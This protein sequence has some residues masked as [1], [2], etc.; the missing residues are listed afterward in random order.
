MSLEDARRRRGVKPPAGTPKTGATFAVGDRVSPADRENVGTVIEVE[1]GGTYV[2]RFVGKEGTA[3]KSFPASSLRPLATPAAEPP[4][5]RR[6]TTAPT[7]S[8]VPFPIEA[9]PAPLRPFVREVAAALPCDPAAVAVPVL[10]ACGAAIG[11]ARVLA[12]KRAWTEPPIVWAGI[13]APSG[14][15]KSPPVEH[16]IAP[17]SKIDLELR[18]GSNRAF[19]E[20]RAAQDARAAAERDRKAEAR[21]HGQSGSGTGLNASNSLVDLDGALE[22]ADGAGP[23]RPPPKRR[24]VVQDITIESLGIILEDNPKGVLIYRDEL[25]SWFGSLTRYSKND[26][27]S[28]WLTLFHARPLTVDRKTGDKIAVAVPNA[29]ASLVGTIQPKVLAAA[30]TPQFRASGGAARL[31]LV[32]PPPQQKVWTEDDL[33]A[34]VEDAYEQIIRR[35]R[36]LE[37]GSDGARTAPV[38]V[39]LTAE[40]RCRWGEFVNE[41]GGKTFAIGGENDDLAAAFSKLEGYAARFA[42]IHH[43]VMAA[44]RPA[45]AGIEPVGVESLDAGIALARWFAQ[46]AERAYALLGEDDRTRRLRELAERVRRAGGRISV[47][48]LQKANSRKYKATASAEA[49][50]EELVVAGFGHWEEAP[51]PAG[52]H[53]NRAFVL[54]TTHDTS[55]T[56]PGHELPPAPAPPD[57]RAAGRP[58]TGGI[59]GD[60]ARVSEVSCVVQGPTGAILPPAAAPPAGPSVVQ[61]PDQKPQ[62]RRYKNDPRPHDRRE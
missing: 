12:L 62:R 2:V 56:R 34:P 3:E 38:P 50:L 29:A 36:A 47:R 5:D 26:T 15:I 51:A 8:F 59:P 31:L 27:T 43:L 10:V 49:D 20:Y 40:G 48:D 54:C 52:G 39:A 37:P 11:A 44:G 17:L 53:P 9:L 21:A 30:L 42:L 32:M 23:L 13:V 24:C 6:A 45:V 46:E 28:D 60:S 1:P 55:D 25:A 57:T 61:A 4:P 18:D 14:S 19:A 7:P 41:W 33:S 35:L 22:R 16:A 58:G